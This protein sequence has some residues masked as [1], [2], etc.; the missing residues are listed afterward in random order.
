MS[1]IDLSHSARADSCENFVGAEPV[2][3]PE[4]HVKVLLSLAH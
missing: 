2:A 3:C 1:A 4:R